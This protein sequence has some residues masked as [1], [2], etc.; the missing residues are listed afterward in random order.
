MEDVLQ[1]SSK[2]HKIGSSGAGIAILLFFFPWL[3]A[4]CQGQEV[5]RASGWQLASGSVN[6]DVDA[7]AALFLVLAAAIF[8]IV[9]AYLAY[10]RGGSLTQI[11]AYGPMAASVIAVLVMIVT[12]STLSDQ[13]SQIGIRIEYLFW[14][15]L[16]YLCFIAVFY[17]G[18]LNLQELNQ[19][20]S[21]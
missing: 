18:Y 15:Y 5:G 3:I 16:V 11:D 10:Q 8:V 19:S 7:F 2:G 14:Y 9:L 4:S 1:K 6:S 20:S 21:V 17:G 12:T 13:A